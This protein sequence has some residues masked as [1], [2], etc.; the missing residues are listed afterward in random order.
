MAFLFDGYKLNMEQ[1]G[2]YAPHLSALISIVLILSISMIRIEPPKQLTKMFESP[3]FRVLFLGLFV[4]MSYRDFNSA[5]IIAIG[6]VFFSG[7]T[8]K[9]ELFDML[10]YNNNEMESSN[11]VYDTVENFDINTHNKQDENIE[12]FESEEYASFA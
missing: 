2:T 1:S 5:M 7:L 4:F 10:N 9:K 8:D 3:V 6:Y 12:G 11:E